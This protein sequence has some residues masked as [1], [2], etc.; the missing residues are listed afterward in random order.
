MKLKNLLLVSTTIA[1]MFFSSACINEGR[2]DSEK[3]IAIGKVDYAWYDST[4]ALYEKADF[5]IKGKVL[6]S[7]VEWMSHVIEP[8]AEEKSDPILNPDGEIDDDKMITTIY[9]VEINVVYKGS[10]GKTIEVLQLGGETDTATY[11]YEGA[12]EI[13]I[14]KEYILF[15]SESTLYENAGWLLNNAQ[16]LYKVEGNDLIKLPQNTLELTYEDLARLEK[17]Q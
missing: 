1:L 6:N 14:N 2:T 12:P 10:L 3:D 4:D 5:V 8:T 7:R 16:A 11:S 17:S 15:L 9:T 13:T